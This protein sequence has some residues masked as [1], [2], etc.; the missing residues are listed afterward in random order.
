MHCSKIGISIN[1]FPAGN[2]FTWIIHFRLEQIQIIAFISQV[3]LPFSRRDIL[4]KNLK[5]FIFVSKETGMSGRLGSILGKEN[6]L[7]ILRR[8]NLFTFY[9]ENLLLKKSNCWKWLLM[10]RFCMKAYNFSITER[11]LHS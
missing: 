11:F 5:D 2:Q 8:E 9:F 10:I 4:H 3:F 7:S 1:E 6:F